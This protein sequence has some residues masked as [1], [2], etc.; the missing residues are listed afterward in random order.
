M[1]VVPRYIAQEMVITINFV[2]QK[3]FINFFKNLNLRL[4]K[5]K[6]ENDILTLN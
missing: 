4:I 3:T 2:S 1:F 6:T 5:Q